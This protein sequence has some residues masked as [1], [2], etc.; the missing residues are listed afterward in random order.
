MY[1][2]GYLQGSE[3]G[4]V[5]TIAKKPQGRN[6]KFSYNTFSKF[7]IGVLTWFAIMLVPLWR[8]INICLIFLFLFVI[9]FTYQQFLTEFAGSDILFHFVYMWERTKFLGVIW[10]VNTTN[11]IARAAFTYKQ[12]E[13]GYQNWQILLKV[14]DR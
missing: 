10:L 1:V 11:Q 8:I 2:Q 14:A 5:V 13:R 9:I 6:V 7:C 12:N 3:N 4:R